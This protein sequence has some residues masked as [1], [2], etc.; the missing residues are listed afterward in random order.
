MGHC[1]RKD[2][3]D[4]ACSISPA[5]GWRSISSDTCCAACK[6]SGRASCPSESHGPSDGYRLLVSLSACLR[7]GI[8]SMVRVEVRHTSPYPDEVCLEL[9]RRSRASLRHSGIAGSGVEA[10]PMAGRAGVILSALLRLLWRHPRHAMPLTWRGLLVLVV[11]GPNSYA[12]ALRQI[13]PGH[14][15]RVRPYWRAGYVFALAGAIPLRGA[16]LDTFRKGVENGERGRLNFADM[17]GTDAHQGRLGPAVAS[18]PP[19]RPMPI[20]FA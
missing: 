12:D 5:S 11:Q 2:R 14:V 16:I 13:P 6:P 17:L 3:L 20:G 10:L 15:P 7:L 8:C 18:A 4:P 9:A 19:C 1:T